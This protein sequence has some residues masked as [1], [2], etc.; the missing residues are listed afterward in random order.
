VDDSTTAVLGHTDRTLAGT[1]GSLLLERL[2]ARTGNFSAVLDLV[3]AL[4]SGS[5][6]SNNNLVDERHVGHN[7]E[8]RAGKLYCAGLLASGVNDGYL[9]HGL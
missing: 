5:Q 8:H 7:I 4:A 6:L 1:T 2:A 9:R 3:R